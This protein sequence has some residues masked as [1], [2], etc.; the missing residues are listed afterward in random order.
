MGLTYHGSE[1]RKQ[2]NGRDG[3]RGTVQAAIDVADGTM[4][5]MTKTA[6]FVLLLTGFL[7][8]NGWRNNGTLTIAS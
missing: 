1:I 8:K 7:Y 3:P 2:V 5:I 6:V 4:D